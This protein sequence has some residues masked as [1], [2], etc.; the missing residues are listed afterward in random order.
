MSKKKLYLNNVYVKQSP[1]HG[2][3]VFAGKKLRKGELLEECYMI[4]TK[5][6]DKTLDD[7]YFEAKKKYAVFT[8]YGSIYNHSDEPNA[9]Y[10]LNLKTS[11]VTIRADRTIQKGDEIFITYGEDWF[12]SRGL[13]AKNRRKLKA[14]KRRR[15][16][17]KN[18][19]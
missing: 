3:G 11:I 6:G 19:K 2:F 15:S 7:Y 5:G 8:G 13:K 18:R 12:S 4:I 10:I 16:K 17:A 9:D 14:K 1:T